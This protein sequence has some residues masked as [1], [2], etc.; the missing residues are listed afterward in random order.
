M[1]KV[2][3]TPLR[4]ETRRTWGILDIAVCLL[5]VT[6]VSLYDVKLVFLGMQAVAFSVVGLYVV[7]NPKSVR[8]LALHYLLWL[9]VFTFYGALSSLWAARENATALSVTFSVLQVG[10]VAFCVMFYAVYAKR[11]NR[12]LYS[13][14]AAAMVFC[15]RFFITV[16]S[17]MWGQAERVEDFGIFGSNMPAMVMAYGS[18]ILVWMCFFSPQKIKRKL[19]ALACVT[20]FMM[21]SILM[22]TRKSLLI[23]GVAVILFMLG[24]AKNPVKLAWRLLLIG[25]AA[26]GAYLMMMN[27]PLLYNSIGYRMESLF[28]L[29]GG[30]E[31]DASA[32][33][34]ANHIESALRLFQEHPIFGAGQ[35]GYRYTTRILT[36]SHNNYVELLANLGITGFS[37]YYVIYIRLLSR[38]VQIF[39]KNML[40]VAFILAILISDIGVVSYSSELIY[41]VVGMVVGMLSLADVQS[42][43]QS[44]AS[45]PEQKAANV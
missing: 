36:Y 40:P 12:I 45:E 37:L 24:S 21:I 17:S 29:F 35:D 42:T 14:I 9:V 1:N 41:V 18:I 31:A 32:V 6:S 15:V 22:G 25:G 43:Y 23:F 39:K 26:V 11:M 5:I 27:I 10:L 44:L 7:A 19:P 13:F 30:G 34:R 2:I 28:Q 8:G 16:P 33:A 20:L 3:N 4:R 38:S